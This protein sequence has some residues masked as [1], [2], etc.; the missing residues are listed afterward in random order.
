MDPLT[1][2]L[3]GAN[4]AATP[5]GRTSRF[6]PA[7]LVVGANLPDVD[8]FSYAISPD[9]AIGF[10]RGWT[11]G[12]LALVVL[13]LIL[14]AILLLLDRVRPDEQRA[15]RPRWLLFLAILGI[16]S[17][18]ALD[19][20]NNYGMRWLMPFRETWY[21]GDSVF[22]MDPWLWV[23]L[24]G[25][26]LAG[27]RPSAAL[28]VSWGGITTIILLVVAGRSSEYLLL[29]VL[30]ALLLLAALLWHPL[31]R[32]EWSKSV[33]V[34]VALVLALAYILLRISLHSA[35]L[36]NVQIALAHRDIRAMRV[37]V[38]PHPVDPFEWDVVVE[39]PEA[40]RHGV[41][42]LRERRLDLASRTIVIDRKSS[43]WPLVRN[44][45]STR[46]FMSWARFPWY[47]AATTGAGLE[48]HLGDARYARERTS[49][50]G[51]A[52]VTLP[53]K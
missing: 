38:A 26:W 37:M 39:T 24:G 19:W 18:P 22:I 32:D 17:H 34:T 6:G 29:V 25:A 27:R 35:A 13:P 10:R 9:F 41:Y 49:G 2:T 53:L 14:T 1:H 21:Y 45:P 36:A 46:G 11:H 12:V 31:A 42:H 15:A 30:I 23:I 48:V 5:L 8:L 7:A 51:G 47:E 4:I 20:L 43:L 50:F 16:A 3:L 44:H 40:Y 28:L 33:A 52:R